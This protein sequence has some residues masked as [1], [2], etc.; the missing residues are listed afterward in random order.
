LGT[1]GEGKNLGPA[2]EGSSA[3]L[4]RREE[5]EA[6]SL[7]ADVGSGSL[8]GSSGSVFNDRSVSAQVSDL[9]VPESQPSV[10]GLTKAQAWFF[11]WMRQGGQNHENLLAAV[12]RF[13]EQTRRDNEVA[14]PDC[15]MELPQ[16]KAELEAVMRDMYS[17][18]TTTKMGSDIGMDIGIRAGC[19]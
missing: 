19:L 17:G 2:G 4:L 13:E 3:N 5:E 14:P 15:S 1:V 12:D 16:L 11:G 18:A 10:N 8:L 7:S 6:R 9:P